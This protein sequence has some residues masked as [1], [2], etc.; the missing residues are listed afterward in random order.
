MYEWIRLISRVAERIKNHRLSLVSAGMAFYAILS[1]F[2]ALTALLSI[3]GLIA[4]PASVAHQVN[5]LPA[6]LPPA[7]THMIQQQIGGISQG[8]SAALTLGLVV[9][10]VLAVYSASKSTRALVSAL[11][12]A[13]GLSDNRGFIRLYLHTYA[14]TFGAVWLV[15]VLL[16]LIGLSGYI[17]AIDIGY[18]AEL[19]ISW[20]R[21]LVIVVLM[22]IAL[23]VVYA[24]AL[25]QRRP[26]LRWLIPGAVL[27]T[28]TWLLISLA[29]SFYIANFGTYNKV[30]GSAAAIMIL[31]IW[32][33]LSAF[34]VLIGAELN[35]ELEA[36]AKDTPGA[37]SPLNTIRQRARAARG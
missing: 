4:D 31:L 2:P 12:L 25:Y 18:W 24:F 15:I 9:S 26:Y 16:A 36:T 34:A 8:P 19:V 21:W 22:M 10:I 3:Y 11:N 23:G 5:M 14:L 35:A 28:V 29:F 32:F 7:L 6:K 33:N 20:L 37:T 13:Y 17:Q 1:I 30:Y 27:A